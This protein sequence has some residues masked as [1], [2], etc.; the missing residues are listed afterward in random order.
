MVA[1]LRAHA[2][3]Q[4]ELGELMSDLGADDKEALDKIIAF[5]RRWGL[6]TP[7]IE[8]EIYLAGFHRERFHSRLAE[9]SHRGYS[10]KWL[11]ERGYSLDK[12]HVYQAGQG[13]GADKPLLFDGRTVL[14][15]DA[16]PVPAGL[17]CSGHTIAICRRELDLLKAGDFTT[18]ELLRKQ[19]N[20]HDRD[21]LRRQLES[22]GKN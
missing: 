1:N 5:R 22:M 2:Q 11:F 13:E 12:D 14:V 19:I 15:V 9:P 6:P 18:G 21:S 7:D 4:S 17:R 10:G 8:P 20:D 3:F 16:D